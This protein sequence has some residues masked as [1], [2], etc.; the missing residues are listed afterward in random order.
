MGD[1]S[2]PSFILIRLFGDIQL[3]IL[4]EKNDIKL[5]REEE[6]MP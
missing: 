4:N 2:L 5:V 6:A 3:R 1:G